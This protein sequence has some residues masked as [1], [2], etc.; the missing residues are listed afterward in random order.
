MGKE[1]W[2][3]ITELSALTG[4]KQ[5]SIRRHLI[6]D[7]MID[8]KARKVG[9]HWEVSQIA[10]D[11]LVQRIQRNAAKESP[12]NIPAPEPVAPVDVAL[13]DDAFDDARSEK[14]KVILDKVIQHVMDAPLRKGRITPVDE[15]G[16]Q[17]VYAD[18]KARSIRVIAENTSVLIELHPKKSQPQEQSPAMPN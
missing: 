7:W 18:P 12:N 1:R 4:R 3:T 17:I 8:G 11:E 14:A 6:E 16:H 9:D 15:L 13:T 5:N 10:Y 2:Y